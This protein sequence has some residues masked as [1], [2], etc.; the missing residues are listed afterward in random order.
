MKTYLLTGCAGFIA[1]RVGAQLLAAGHRVVG[2]DNLNDA[3]DP[4][5]KLWRLAKLQSHD[6]FQFHRF[7]VAE[8]DEMEQLFASAGRKQGAPPFDGV[9]HLAARA[10]VQPSV[11]D[12]WTYF[13]SNLT[14]TLN[15]LECCRRNNAKKFVLASTSSAYGGDTPIPFREDADTSRPLSPYAASK[16]AAETLAFTY[17][18]LHGIDVSV[19]RFFTVYG[20]AGRPDM[21]IFRFIKRI[22]AGQ[23]IV[24]FGDGRQERDFTFVDDIARGVV[25]SLRPVGYEIINLGGDEPVSLGEAIERIAGLLSQSVQIDYRPAHAADVR[26]TW[27]DIGKAKSL[28]DW[29][30]QT[31]FSEGLR[32]TVEWYLENQG[33]VDSLSDSTAPAPPEK[34]GAPSG[35]A[36]FAGLL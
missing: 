12:P 30:P 8:R 9:L 19:L 25:A 26:S 28:L 22:G 24:V 23:P 6:G 1:S 4:R 21:S 27:A 11:E 35:D 2:V 31:S 15:L 34:S 33:L 20:P 36:T 14:G 16:K 3:Y 18:H 10:G 5:L 32:N 13:D 29:S 7:D 17:H